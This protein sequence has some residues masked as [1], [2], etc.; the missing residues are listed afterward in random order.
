MAI[1]RPTARAAATLPFFCNCL[2]PSRLIRFPLRQ[3]HVA[4][5]Y[6]ARESS[7]PT[8]RRP[9]FEVPALLLPFRF[10]HLHHTREGRVSSPRAYGARRPSS[11]SRRSGCLLQKASHRTETQSW[12]GR[13]L[14]RSIPYGRTTQTTDQNSAHG[15]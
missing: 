11:R 15:F 8:R 1:K 14:D 13:G 10:A 12:R 9:A 5:F 4:V 6:N 2:L 3:N 7:L